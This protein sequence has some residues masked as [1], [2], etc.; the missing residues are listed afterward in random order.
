MDQFGLAR[1][2]P[3]SVPVALI[4]SWAVRWKTRG[5]A[6]ATGRSELARE[7]REAAERRADVARGEHQAERLRRRRVGGE[8]RGE[9][10][11]AGRG[12]GG[13]TS[14]G[15]EEDKKRL[16]KVATGA[17]DLQCMMMNSMD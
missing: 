16:G 14:A 6:S 1:G 10:V 5:V 4:R 17:C 11:P 8:E 12:G 2:S 13:R 7:A 9:R 15:K 3:S